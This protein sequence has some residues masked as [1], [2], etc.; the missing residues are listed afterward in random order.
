MSIPKRLFYHGT[1]VSSLPGELSWWGEY[2]TWN[3]FPSPYSM[4]ELDLIRR[5]IQCGYKRSG[6]TLVPFQEGLSKKSDISLGNFFKEYLNQGGMLDINLLTSLGKA[7]LKKPNAWP[8]LIIKYPT[9]YS[10]RIN[11][12]IRMKIPRWRDLKIMSSFFEMKLWIEFME[13]IWRAIYIAFQMSNIK[14]S[15]YKRS[16]LLHLRR[17]IV[18]DP[19]QVL[20]DLMVL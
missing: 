8:K 6:R 10:E 1:L 19:E 15:G 7:W 17:E 5:C 14:I 9:M 11:E 12:N 2:V 20:E 13:D 16:I 4:R 18:L 3:G